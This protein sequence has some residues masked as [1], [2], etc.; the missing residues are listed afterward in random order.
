MATIS[1]HHALSSMGAVPD[2]QRAKLLKSAG[3]NPQWLLD[4][5]RRVHTDQAARLFRAVMVALN[6]EWMGFTEGGTRLGSFATLCELGSRCQTLNE[7]LLKACSFYRLIN[8]EIRLD[9]ISDGDTARF[10]VRLRHPEKD[11]TL[12]LTEFLLVIFH[13]MPSWFINTPIPL[14]ET[15]FRFP[16]PPH[17]DELRVMFRTQLRFDQPLNALIFDAD[18]LDYP[19][20][21]SWEEI[22]SF[23][24]HAPAGVMTIP[25]TEGTLER[26]IERMFNGPKDSIFPN[27][28]L[29]DV[30]E[31]LKMNTQTLHRRLQQDGTSFQ[32]IKDNIRRE[33]AIKHLSL[34]RQP[35]ERIAEITGFAEAR[36][37]TRAFRQWTGLS[38]REFRASAR[39]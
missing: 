29:G 17:V 12:F 8:D 5:N 22:K 21:R 15:R 34:N 13:R 18:L 38:P 24:Q 19:V 23:I 2:S 39:R 33:I 36:S 1:H 20:Q 26:Q 28:S 3:I 16:A 9:L 4:P 27:L 30:A 6:D 32:R 11:P 25:G 14:R 35:I 10:A 31:R 7:L 37:F